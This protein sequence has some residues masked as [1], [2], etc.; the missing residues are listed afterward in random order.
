MFLHQSGVIFLNTIL[1]VIALLL[2]IPIAVIFIECLA[3]L[4]PSQSQEEDISI[5]RPRVSVLIPA[6]NEASGIAETLSTL[7]QDLTAQ[8]NMIVIADNCTDETAMIASKFGA[9]VIKRNEPNLRGKGFA[10]DCGLNFI[11]TNPP[12]VVVMLDADCT[13]HRGTIER[14]ARMAVNLKRPVQATNLLAIP[15]NPKPKDA[16]SSLAFTV[17]NLVRQRGL[18][19][20]RLP[21]LLTGT[22]MAFPWLLIS[23]TSLASDNIVEDKQL[24]FDLTLAG[25]PPIFCEEALVTGVLPQE[26]QAAKTQRTRWTHGHLQ[27]LLTEVPVLLKASVEQRR[28]DLFALALD[29]SV[30]PLSLLIMLWI[31]VMGITS[32]SAILGASWTPG[33]FV[34]V[35][36]LLLLIAI[37]GAWAKFGRANLPLHTLL[38]VPLYIFWKIP[39]YWSFLWRPQKAWIRTQR[40]E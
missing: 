25:Y 15:A 40:D 4:L 3:A 20:L 36:G 32:L 28:F 19:R 9:T 33:F 6:H 16:V 18:K 23:E 7:K 13:I 30:P 27:T 10:L 5:P 2:A 37:V 39:V 14:L 24:G 31:V 22:G 34:G 17:K 35:Q 1:L 29:L 26:E 8:D 38:S 21:G 11:K 12:E